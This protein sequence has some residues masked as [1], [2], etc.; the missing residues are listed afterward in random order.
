MSF[1][2]QRSAFLVPLFLCGFIFS[3][4]LL[5][6]LVEYVSPPI[7]LEIK[8]NIEAGN[9]MEIYINK[10]FESPKRVAVETAVSKT[11]LVP[12]VPSSIWHIRIDPT[13]IPDK[14]FTICSL[15]LFAGQDIVAQVSA[16]E[17]AKWGESGSIL[18]SIENNC[19]VF[20]ALTND[21]FI[22]AGDLKLNAL[23][24]SEDRITPINILKYLG[25]MIVA[26]GMVW[27]TCNGINRYLL[28]IPVSA[29]LVLA[30]FLPSLI[31][32]VQ[33]LP[34]SPPPISEAVGYVAYI[35]YP[36]SVD[37]LAF[38]FSISVFGLCGLLLAILIR[39]RVFQPLQLV[40]TESDQRLFPEL[41][42]FTLLAMI[43]LITFP[44]L[45]SP[46]PAITAS[47]F[48]FNNML[49]WGYLYHSGLLPYRDFWFP[50]A[51]QVTQLGS[52]PSD[53]INIYLHNLISISIF[54]FALFK[55]FRRNLIYTLIVA[56]FVWYPCEFGIFMGVR[57]YFVALNI[58]L[59]YAGIICE[60]KFSTLSALIFSLY[61]GLA[62]TF[63][64]NQLLYAAPGVGLL[65]L[66]TIFLP[67]Q[68]TTDFRQI[69][70]WHIVSAV[71][72]LAIL[73]FQIWS[74]YINDQLPQFINFFKEMTVLGMRAALPAPLSDWFGFVDS[75]NNIL[76]LGLHY[77][78]L[79]SIF[80]LF[81]SKSRE[82]RFY[83]TTTLA[84][85]AVVSMLFL[86]HLVRP[87][88][89]QQVIGLLIVGYGIYFWNLF[90]SLNTN[91]I[92]ALTF[93]FGA[94]VG[95]FDKQGQI[96]GGV[97]TA[98]PYLLKAPERIISAFDAPTDNDYFK[99]YY[100]P[101]NFKGLDQE[102]TEL[103]NFFSEQSLRPQGRDI[104]VLGDDSYLY[105]ILNQLPPE[106][107]TL[108]DGAAISAQRRMVAR[109]Q[110]EQPRFVIFN[111]AFKSFDGV[112]NL[113]RNPI[114]YNHIIS[115]YVFLNQVGRFEILIPKKPE[116]E[117][118]ISYWLNTLGSSVDLGKLPY[119]SSFNSGSECMDNN[120]ISFL[121]V[122]GSSTETNSKIILKNNNHEFTI[123][124]SSAGKEGF[125]NLNQIW[126][127]NL[128]DIK[129]RA[130]VITFS[131]ED[132]LRHILL[133]RRFSAEI[134][135]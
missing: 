50:Y 48:D 73:V 78:I 121:S 67:S 51:G 71:F 84:V 103:V 87:H 69:I 86:K 56:A 57:R 111:T 85:A 25:L 82:S 63:E 83:F 127:W 131:A 44:D 70:K 112:P 46:P 94:L 88:M 30:H 38:F 125:I 72:F 5:F 12:N 117:I 74:L 20:K 45:L 89:A 1:A 98:W 47:E 28:V 95:N 120:C 19:A 26:I 11:Y 102:Q 7:R 24:G 33:S 8:A 6:D 41:C 31:S 108:Y 54:L 92:W 27:A 66:S 68:R 61:C 10:N 135:Y 90:R 9:G 97:V 93:I 22:W 4:Y 13:D 109:L 18:K 128:L 105:L 123:N 15:S 106:F 21:P 113:V 40:D 118:D 59:L 29:T 133:T 99:R 101:D 32:I 39:N 35:G 96:V 119:Y 91:R 107:L 126:F 16:E 132:G 65:L 116:Q 36:K 75:Y 42:L 3:K 76:V 80:G 115:N 110:K 104:F 129:D 64:P 17:L 114:I 62:L 81:F 55:I 58:A 100:A 23:G 52:F 14:E 79:A 60:G 49:G 130:S 134:L 2:N 124:F 53:K 43:A 122:D 37:N 34:L 77:L